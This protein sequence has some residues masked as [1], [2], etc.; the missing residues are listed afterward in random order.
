MMIAASILGLYGM[1]LFYIVI[2]VHLVGLRSFG[3]YYTAPIA[4]Y[5][6]SN[7]LDLIFRAPT[8][9]LRKRPMELKTKD[10]IT[11]QKQ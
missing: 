4:P 1:I 9:V 7:W 8:S 6:F 2:N 10:D 5:Q 3:S 11:Q